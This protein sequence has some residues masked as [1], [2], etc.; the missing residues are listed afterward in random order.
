MMTASLAGTSPYKALR[1]LSRLCMLW[2]ETP[3]TLDVTTAQYLA[4]T[5]GTALY[6]QTASGQIA[7]ALNE[8]MTAHVWSTTKEEWG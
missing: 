1:G 2:I 6:P 3:A 7:S 4:I 5:G 8:R